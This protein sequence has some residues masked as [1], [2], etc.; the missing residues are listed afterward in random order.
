MRSQPAPAKP[1][2]AAQRS[3]CQ[4]LT[5]MIVSAKLLCPGMPIVMQQAQSESDPV[6][7]EFDVAC[8]SRQLQFILAELDALPHCEIAALRIDEAINA[9]S[10]SDDGQD[11]R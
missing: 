4:I 7:S 10:G 2:F 8:I 5:L 3:S 9:L 6:E 1:I 11:Q